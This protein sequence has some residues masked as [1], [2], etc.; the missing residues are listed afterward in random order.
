MSQSREYS[1]LAKR[2]KRLEKKYDFKERITGPTRDQVDDLRAFELL[3]HAELEVYFEKKALKVLERAK[4]KWESQHC[5]NYNLA[6]LFLYAGAIKNQNTP[7]ST[8]VGKV[9]AD[10]CQKVDRNN[11]IKQDNIKSL[12]R[13]LGFK[14]DDFDSILMN[15]LD[16]LGSQRG[17]FAHQSF[18]TIEITSKNDIFKKIDDI[19]E[20]IKDFERV[21]YEKMNGDI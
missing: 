19:V 7:I 20:E 2:I 10:Y 1:R 4:K 16:Q 21:L 11:G 18:K 12:Y 8:M 15:N 14:M 5:A 9:I 3:C 13:P 17:A 6:C